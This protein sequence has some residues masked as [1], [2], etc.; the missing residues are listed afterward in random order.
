MTSPGRPA[1]DLGNAA[2][3]PRQASLTINEPAAADSFVVAIGASGPQGLQDIGRVL[4]GLPT[5]LRAV[6]M[7][8]LHRPSDQVSHLRAILSRATK[9]PVLIASQDLR[10]QEGYCY[11]GEPDAH[12]ELAAQSL[13]NMVA[14]QGNTHRN[15]TVDLLFKSV[16]SYAGARFIGVVLSGSLDDGSRGLAVIHAAGGITMVLT[17]TNPVSRGMPE[18]AIAYGQPIDV[19]GSPERIAAEILARV[20]CVAVARHG[21]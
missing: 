3:E 18:N 2:G 12:L 14:G 5:G 6:V 13:G 9:L 7:V 10:L 11:I 19:I 16:A 17:P 1:E 4:G 15:R 20:G 8:V 21:E